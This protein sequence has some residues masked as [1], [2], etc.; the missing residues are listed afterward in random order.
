MWHNTYFLI[1]A[2]LLVA[3]SFHAGRTTRRAKHVANPRGLPGRGLSLLSA[4]FLAG[5]PGR[6]FDTALVRMHVAERAVISRGGTVTITH[7]RPYD[8]V[9]QAIMDS[10]GPTRSRGVAALRADV[11]RS[12]AVQALGDDL[13]D[14]GLMRHPDRLR[15]ARRAR[16]LLWLSLLPVP[17]AALLALLLDDGHADRPA[18][19]VPV[20]LLVFGLASLIGTRPPRDRI[21]LAGRSQLVLMYVGKPWTPNSGLYPRMTGGAVLGAIALGGLAAAAAE[22]GIEELQELL[23]GAAAQ[24][25]AVNGAVG[26]SSSYSSGVGSSSCSGAS[27]GGSAAWC[28]SSDSGSS[29]SSHHSGCGSSSSSCG[30]SHSSCGGSSSSCGSSGSSCGSSSS[31]CGSSCGGGCGS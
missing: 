8:A 30:S 24:Q 3:A 29:G 2:A 10:A 16:R 23:V 21:T 18:L 1:P 11:M 27:C 31:S 14:R 20:V 25:A 22:P 15:A 4:A 19:W 9:D 17:A 13:A 26:G 6:V 7:D 28:G 5:G 12:P